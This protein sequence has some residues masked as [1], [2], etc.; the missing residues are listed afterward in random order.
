MIPRGAKPMSL[1]NPLKKIG[2]TAYHLWIGLS[3]A[4]GWVMTRVILIVVFYGVVTPIALVARLFGK[5]FLDI[6]YRAP[7]RQSYWHEREKKA[8]TETTR[9]EKQF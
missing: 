8:N 9:Y 7:S 6:S 4:M 1:I 3:F 2:K 5:R